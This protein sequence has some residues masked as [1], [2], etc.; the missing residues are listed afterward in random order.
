[1][2]AFARRGKPAGSSL[3]TRSARAPRMFPMSWIQQTADGCVISVRVV[4]RAS[5]NQVQG[6]LG[7]ALKIRLQAPPVEGKANEALVR[8]LAESLDIPPRSV[9]LLS[10]E[11][12][13]NKRIL[14][15]G[16]DAG[17]A[18]ARLGISARA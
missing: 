6:I 10:G 11:T 1:M 7:D 18:R 17:Q 14:L 12:G 13:R 16:M 15:A 9:R 2:P 8:F 3:L 5:K 4:P